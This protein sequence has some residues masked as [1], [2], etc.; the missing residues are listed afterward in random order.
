[1]SMH[2]YYCMLWIEARDQ[3]ASDFSIIILQG[4]TVNELEHVISYNYCSDFNLF[5][6]SRMD[7]GLLI[8]FLDIFLVHVRTLLKCELHFTC[9]L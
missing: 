1:M 8:H 6:V 2:A 4:H 7:G 5:K 9:C 3:L